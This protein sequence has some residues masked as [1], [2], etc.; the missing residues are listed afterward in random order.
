MEPITL[1]F[2]DLSSPTSEIGQSVQEWQK[3]VTEKSDGKITFENYFSSALFAA[4]EA[5]GQVGS[6][7]ADIGYYSVGYSP[8]EMSVANW[9]PGG[10]TALASKSYPGGLLQGTGGTVQEIYSN[11]KVLA[12]FEEHNIHPT[13]S[14]RSIHSPVVP[15]ALRAAL[16]KVRSK[17][18]V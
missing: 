8:Q 12:Q 3:R 10:A 1:T 17:R 14:P 7:V 13:P 11:D 6:G 18:S 16:T 15:C 2:S 5:L 9:V 4:N